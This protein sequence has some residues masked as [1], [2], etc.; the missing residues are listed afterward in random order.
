MTKASSHFKVGADLH[1][2]ID[3]ICAASQIP[4]YQTTFQTTRLPKDVMILETSNPSVIP[5]VIIF[6]L[7]VLH[8]PLSYASTSK[9][10]LEKP[11]N[12]ANADIERSESYIVTRSVHT[13]C[14]TAIFDLGALILRVLNVSLEV[15]QGSLSVSQVR[16]D[17]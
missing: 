14:L 10:C 6:M 17:D 13:A 15:R 8:S 4:V 12:G 11:Q 2:D 3:T 9:S 1:V 5:Q 7:A 16:V